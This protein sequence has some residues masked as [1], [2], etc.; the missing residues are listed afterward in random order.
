MREITE[1]EILEIASA[2]VYETTRDGSCVQY[3]PQKGWL[4]FIDTDDEEEV[5]ETVSHEEFL[6]KHAEYMLESVCK[7]NAYLATKV[8]EDLV[9]A[10]KW[11]RYA[12]YVTYDV[13]KE[14]VIKAVEEILK[15]AEEFGL[16]RKSPPAHWRKV[17]EKLLIFCDGACEPHNPGGAAAWGF[18]VVDTQTGEVLNQASGVA[19]VGNGATNNLAEFAAVMAALR[20]VLEC[21]WEKTS[22]K[23]LTDSQLVVRILNNE[24]SATPGKGYFSAYQQAKD[25]LKRVRQ[26]GNKVSIS[27]IPREQNTIADNLSKSAAFQAYLQRCN[28]NR[29]RF[30]SLKRATKCCICEKELDVGTDVAGIPLRKGEWKIFCKHHVEVSVQ[31][32]YTEEAN[33]NGSKSVCS[34]EACEVC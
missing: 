21:E 6:E 26:R 16:E 22:I 23:I 1:Q 31:I 10:E 25:L 32:N 11:E 14:A 2:L 19:A 9:E 30:F 7:H 29:L 17:S 18:A 5:W 8:L 20:W 4:V 3:D 15:R 27:W 13:V 24:W 28:N 12:K 34:E 33:K